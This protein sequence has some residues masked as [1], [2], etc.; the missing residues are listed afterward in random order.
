MNTSS[1]GAGCPNQVS[2]KTVDRK[3]RTAERATRTNAPRATSVATDILRF[4]ASAHTRV[5]SQEVYELRKQLVEPVFGIIRVSIVVL[6]RLGLDG[7]GSR[8]D[9]DALSGRAANP[10]QTGGYVGCQF[11]GKLC[12]SRPPLLI[13]ARSKEQP[14][15]P[16]NP[17]VF[18]TVLARFRVEQHIVDPMTRLSGAQ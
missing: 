16:H 5:H 14:V 8:L 13:P 4:I 12:T 6:R 15:M 10:K 17:S 7:G 9:E 3:S 1:A 2:K 11:Y 18:L